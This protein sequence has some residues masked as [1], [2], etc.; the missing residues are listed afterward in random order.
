[1]F[2]RVLP[3]YGFYCRHLR[4]LKLRDIETRYE[5]EEGR[6]A[7]VAE[8]VDTL[9]LAGASLGVDPDSG[10]CVRLNQVKNAFIHGCRAA[11]SGHPY[12]RS[13]GSR[14][15]CLAGN[16]LTGASQEIERA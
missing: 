6:P 1:M 11:S 4:N 15:I 5:R 12:I 13:I 2:G 14:E 8:D 10:P 7:L 16:D 3:A 9:E